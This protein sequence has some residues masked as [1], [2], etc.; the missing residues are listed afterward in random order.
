MS[1]DRKRLF[2]ALQLQRQNV[3]VNF[4]WGLQLCFPMPS[5]SIKSFYV[6]ELGVDVLVPVSYRVMSS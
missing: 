1:V 5:L 4:A 3:C 6:N 2:N